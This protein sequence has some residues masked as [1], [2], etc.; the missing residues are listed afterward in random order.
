M[1]GCACFDDHSFYCHDSMTLYAVKLEEIRL[2]T[3]SSFWCSILYSAKV[4]S[5]FF[6][7]TSGLN[8]QI[9]MFLFFFLSIGKKDHKIT[10]GSHSLYIPHTFASSQAGSDSQRNQRQKL[11]TFLLGTSKIEKYSFCTPENYIM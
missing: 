6:T 11:Q 4:Y 10:K 5:F 1:T 7:F 8:M 9:F 2:D 3:H